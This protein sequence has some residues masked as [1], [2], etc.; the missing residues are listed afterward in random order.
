[1]AGFGFSYETPIF[2]VHSNNPHHTDRLMATFAD[3]CLTR[4]G[5]TPSPMNIE[6]SDCTR[7]PALRCVQDAVA[8][9]TN[10]KFESN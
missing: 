2:C 6:R 3:H 8:Q 10:W 5:I 9:G 1:M 4:Y 7:R